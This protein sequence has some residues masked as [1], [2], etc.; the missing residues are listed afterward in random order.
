MLIALPLLGQ[1]R[2]IL[3]SARPF[4]I[5][6]LPYLYLYTAMPDILCTSPAAQGLVRDLLGADMLSQAHLVANFDYTERLQNW[7]RGVFREC[8]R[9]QGSLKEVRRPGPVQSVYKPEQLARL[10]LVV[11]AVAITATGVGAGMLVSARD[12]RPV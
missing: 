4:T 8:S 10:P 1:A 9:T 7:G 11:A 5:L 3:R 2:S 12:S 6:P